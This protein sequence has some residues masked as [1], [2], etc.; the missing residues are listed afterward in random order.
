MRI[1][2]LVV[3]GSLLLAAGAAAAA[4]SR[5]EILADYLRQARQA[6][7]AFSG[8]SVQRGEAMFKARH[9]ANPNVPACTTCHTEDPAQPGRHY[10]TG[11]AIEPVA[12]SRTPTRFTDPEKV[13]E[14]FARD[15]KNVLG[16]PCTAAEKG[17]YIAFMAA[18]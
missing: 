4:S 18:R 6:D 16:R 8:F 13:E 5:E 9:S 3:G 12:V 7:P 2:H 15:C 10:K 11:R 1:V 14:R 17:D